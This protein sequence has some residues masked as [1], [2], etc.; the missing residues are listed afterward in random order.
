MKITAVLTT[1]WQERLENIPQILNDLKSSSRP[2]DEILLLNNN[3]NYT[4]GRTDIKV[5]NSM[6]NWGSEGR[7]P[8]ALLEPSDYYL[9]LDDDLTVKSETIANLEKMAEKYPDTA[10]GLIGK[11]VEKGKKYETGK[12]VKAIDLE[13]AEF[14][15]N[16]IRFYFV[17]KDIV[18]K[19]ALEMDYY[20]EEEDGYIPDDLVLASVSHTLVVPA[21]NEEYFE[22]MDDGG[23]GYERREN[24][25]KLRNKYF[26]EKLSK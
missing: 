24:H 7:W 18:A 26:K 15:D 22:E 16:L 8:T 17:P 2:S 21:D 6:H 12:L 10:L 1:Y 4:I 20:F 23:V 3:Q 14:V 11:K 19:V 9:F 25:Y 13:E 5:I